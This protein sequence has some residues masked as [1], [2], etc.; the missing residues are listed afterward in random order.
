MKVIS[1]PIEPRKTER[2]I[3]LSERSDDQLILL[4]QSGKKSAF[5]QLVRRHQG[6]VLG[7][8]MKYLGDIN[9][10]RD[11]SQ[12]SFLDL[13]RALSTYEAQ[14][15]FSSYL[16][17]IVINQCRMASR[18]TKGETKNLARLAS[19]PASSLQLSEEFLIRRE[20]RLRVERALDRLSPKLKE[21]LILRY[22]SEMS[23]QEIGDT[24]GLRLGTVK[25][26]IFAG[27]GRL[28]R[29]LESEGR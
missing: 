25:S 15:K 21:V 18:R 13:Y 28:H 24:L 10:A 20:E 19:E 16:A 7:I 5:D 27:M 3:P 1:L 26:R 23:Y 11:V 8:A 12:N 29:I 2:Q 14:G 17:R 6:R 4:A 22:V 9:R